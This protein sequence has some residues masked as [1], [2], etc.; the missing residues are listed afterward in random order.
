[1]SSSFVDGHVVHEEDTSGE[2]YK[3]CP[4]EADTDPNHREDVDQVDHKAEISMLTDKNDQLTV[5]L[6]MRKVHIY[7]ISVSIHLYF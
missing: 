4:S 5:I 3:T 6:P 1:M 7:F 2:R